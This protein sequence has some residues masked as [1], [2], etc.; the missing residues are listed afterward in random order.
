MHHFRY[1]LVLLLCATAIPAIAQTAPI[2]PKVLIVIAHP[3]DET[4]FAATVYKITK[5]LHGTADL[6]LVTNGEGG[7]KYSTLA[8]EYYGKELTDEAVGRK[9]LPQIRKQELQNAGRIIGI[10]NFYFMDQKDAHYGLNEREP[11]DTSWHTQWVR[12]R[13]AQVLKDGQYDFVFCL[14]PVPGTHG[15]HKAA[16]LLALQ[17][18]RAMQ[19]KRP[20]I[21]GGGGWSIG[22]SVQHFRQLKDYTESRVLGDTAKFYVDRDAKF[23]YKNSLDYHVIVNWEIAE[24]KSQGTMQLF[25]NRG[26]REQ[27]WYFSLNGNEGLAKTYDLFEQLKKVPYPSKTYDAM[28]RQQSR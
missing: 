8:E 10:R 16:S 18:V 14:L 7:Y 13:M 25:M 23:G 24:H 15:G 11:L 6:F 26:D 12:E 28:G 3:D 5:E 20:V 2:P 19:G 1:L 4:G 27:F 22:D 21:L 9:Y 17:S